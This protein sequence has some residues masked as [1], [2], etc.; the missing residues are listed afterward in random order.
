MKS[1]KMVLALHFAKENVI[2]KWSICDTKRRWG[3]RY[4]SKNKK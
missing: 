2:R 1:G 3:K 4:D